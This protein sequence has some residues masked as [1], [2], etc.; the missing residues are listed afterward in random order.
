MPA[1]RET[2]NNGD[3]ADTERDMR[4]RDRNHAQCHVQHHKENQQADAH[5]DFRQ[6]QRRQNQQGSSLSLYLCKPARPGAKKWWQ[7]LVAV[8]IS[9][10]FHAACSIGPSLKRMLYHLKVKP[11]LG[12]QLRIVETNKR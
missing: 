12:I 10:E 11:P 3:K 2:D 5:Q 1:R 6:R 9:S 7:K 8:A 4:Q